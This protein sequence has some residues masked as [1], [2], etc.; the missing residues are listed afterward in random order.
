M[1]QAYTNLMSASTEPAAATVQP[2]HLYVRFKPATTD[3][4]A[5][6]G[7]LGYRLSWDPMDESAPAP[8]AV[9]QQTDEIPWVYTVVPVDNVL[10]PNIVH[11]QIEELFL[12]TTEDGDMQ[13][14]DPWEPAP[15]PAPSPCGAQWDPS[16]QCYV[17]NVQCQPSSLSASLARHQ[18]AK[19]KPGKQAQTSKKL[20]KA[21]VSPRA[22]YNEAMRVSK[23]P[24]E[25]LPESS[26][27]PGS[28]ETS[29]FGWG[30]T[31]YHPHGRLMVEDTDFGAVPLRGVKVLSRRWFNFDDTYTDDQGNFSISSGYLSLVKI[32]VEF[33]SNLATTRGVVSGWKF[34]EAVLPISAELAAY[35]KGA[36]ENIAYTITYQGGLGKMRSKGASTWT[37]ATLFNTLAEEQSLS[38]ARGIPAPVRNINV[39]LLPDF[40]PKNG[41]GATPMLRTIAST[42][43]ASRVADFLL[44]ASG[45]ANLAIVKQIIQRQLPDVS[46]RYCNDL[47]ALSTP[48][49]KS[50]LYH[51]L[52]HTQHYALVGNGYW[53]DYISYIVNHGGYGSKTDSDAGRI[54]VGE[55]WGNYIGRTFMFDKYNGTTARGFADTAMMELENQ[56]P[57]DDLDTYN[58][59]WLVYGLYHDMTDNTPE[60]PQTRVIDNVTAFNTASVY[61]GLQAST[62][63]GYQR[64]INNL[65][66]GLQ[67]PQMEQLVTTYRW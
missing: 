19:A 36:M 2:T 12:F 21:K 44:V 31:R 17:T 62:V 41:P 60:P 51:E 14:A 66:N 42:A 10:P 35:E 48:A 1:R 33:K 59:G 64:N 5:D 45:L 53:T 55:G 52:G 18:A 4:L 9:D 3:Q 28:P 65:N 40:P 16:C 11:E 47:G 23:H 8:P 50:L 38:A 49:L 26:P 58:E 56:A 46:I 32:S 37:A 7:D 22:L 29:L 27:A 20:K 54:A 43:I 67:A 39:W 15:D 24:A 25:V 61:R 57:S 30:G 63:R 34:W 6:L 13:D